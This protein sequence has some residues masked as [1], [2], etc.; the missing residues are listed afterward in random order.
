MRR[1]KMKRLFLFNVFFIITLVFMGC[2]EEL[3]DTEEETE[4]K[5]FSVYED[6]KEADE[7]IK[8]LGELTEVSEEYEIGVVLKTLS[9][10]HW[11]EMKNGYED[12][13]DKYGVKIDIQ[14][15][16]TEDDLSGQLSIAET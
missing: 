2:S 10:E 15:A 13:A 14:A 6:S 5:S 3:P 11:K 8:E 1:K 9:N 16:E 12:A 4:G 7:V